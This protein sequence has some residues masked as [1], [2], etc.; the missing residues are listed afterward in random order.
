MDFLSEM[1]MTM[2]LL[3]PPN[4]LESSKRIKRLAKRR[5]VDLEAHAAKTAPLD[6]ASYPVWRHRLAEVQRRYDAV[7]PGT[8]KQW[9][10]DRRNKPERVTFWTAIVVIVLTLIFG[11]ISSITGI[12]QVVAAWQMIP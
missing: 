11:L 5:L 8:F 1:R 12:L 6:L 2:H 4:D 3:F 9:Y 7:K 10:H